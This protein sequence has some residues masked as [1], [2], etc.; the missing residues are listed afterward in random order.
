[1]AEPIS[2][3]ELD[4]LVWHALRDRDENPASNADLVAAA[5][6]RWRRI[7]SRIQ[8]MRKAGRL[9]WRRV[10]QSGYPG[11]AHVCAHGWEV[12]GCPGA[13]IQ[14]DGQFDWAY[15]CAD[16]LRRVRPDP[17]D[18]VIKPPPIIAFECELRIEP[19]P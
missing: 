9:R 7:N 15:G 19:S 6:G 1:M 3:H 11:P 14:E 8:V 13:G 4:W 10:G 5:G 18:G 12:L 2:N 16:C 17:A